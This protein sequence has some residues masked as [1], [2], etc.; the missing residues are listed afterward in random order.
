[1][2]RPLLCFT[3]LTTGQEDMTVDSRE[4]YGFGDRHTPR[5]DGT[6]DRPESESWRKWKDLTEQ[7]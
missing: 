7:R 1:M 4:G 3:R 5:A 2:P 6:V